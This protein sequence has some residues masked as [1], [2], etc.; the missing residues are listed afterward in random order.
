MTE[1]NKLRSL[2]TGSVGDALDVA[3][4]G[5]DDGMLLVYVLVIVF[6]VVVV[7][8]STFQKCSAFARL[9]VCIVR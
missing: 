4:I 3:A 2:R 9:V 8:V 1:D 7:V 6:A 5:G